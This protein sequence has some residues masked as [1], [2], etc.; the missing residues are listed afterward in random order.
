[1][2]PI[3]NALRVIGVFAAFCLVATALVAAGGSPAHAAEIG[4]TA[5]HPTAQPLSLISFA[6]MGL[7]G[8]PVNYTRVATLNKGYRRSTTKLYRTYTRRVMEYRMFDDIPDEEIVPSARLNN[9][10]LDVAAG[11]GAHQADDAGYESRT[12]TPEL[13]E[14]EFVFNHTNSRF[15][16]SL[17]SQAFDKAARA[18]QIIRQ[19]K[20]QSLKCIEAVMRKYGLMTYGFSS[21]VVAIV[22]GNP[23]S[24]TT[25][26]ITLRDA[27]GVSG[28]TD[29]AYLAQ[30]FPV[31]EGVGFIRANALVGAGDVT[32][33]DDVAG[34]ITVE[35]RG[36]TVDLADGD[37]IV[38]AN[39]VIGGTIAETDWQKWNVGILD[40]GFSDEVHGVATSDVPSWKPAVLDTDG[41]S[42]GFIKGRRDKQALENKGDTVLRRVLL[43]N[44]VQNDKDARERQA[45]VWM[46]NSTSMNIDGNASMKGVE[47]IT[48]RFVPPTCAFGIGADAMGKKVLTDKPDEEETIDFGKLF[49]AEDRSALKGG[50]DLI[51]AM[52]FRSRSRITVH[53]NLDEQ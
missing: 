20:Y 31:D 50:V 16:I 22:D 46:G 42:W 53:T 17:R 43:S 49:K 19:I 29:P 32:D 34:T 1:M 44:G 9:I 21:G 38:F 25:A 52:I 41:G 47:E 28:M 10:L 30:M 5:L 48:T 18:N 7:T 35:F 2:K 15:S 14:G 6:L 24:G 33:V 3:R 45:L 37:Q 27:F 8:E 12:E 39:G 40:A 51:S 23:A 13:E 11:V 4:H 36:D 26:T